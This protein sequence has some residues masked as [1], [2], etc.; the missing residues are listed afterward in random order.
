MFYFGDT[1]PH[2][3]YRHDTTRHISFAQRV[4]WCHRFSEGNG[5]VSEDACEPCPAG[6]FSVAVA[7]TAAS[8]CRPCVDGEG[9]LPGALDCWPGVTSVVASNPPPIIVGLSPGDTV[10]IAFTR[11]TNQRLDIAQLLQFSPSIGSVNAKWQAAGA[12]AN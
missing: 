5:T 7:V 9:S 2:F 4:C 10:T 11:A 6:T 3:T 1:P 12:G 8:D